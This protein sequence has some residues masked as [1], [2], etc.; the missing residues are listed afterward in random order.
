MACRPRL[1]LAQISARAAI[2]KQNSKK[3]TARSGPRHH[4]F[5][6]LLQL[7]RDYFHMRN[8]RGS[9]VSRY[10]FKG[11]GAEIFCV[12]S[13]GCTRHEWS[14]TFLVPAVFVLSAALER[15]G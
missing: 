7:R 6:P 3:R 2:A 4:L 5:A 11:E 10:G 13:R 12:R 8:M 1:I 9:A 14:L 15:E